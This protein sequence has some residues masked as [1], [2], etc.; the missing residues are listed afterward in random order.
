[1]KTVKSCNLEGPAIEL[2][3]NPSVMSSIIMLDHLLLF[4]YI[5]LPGFL[6][7]LIFEVNID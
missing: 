5:I 3:D 7:C 4:L 1:M 2:I 6:E